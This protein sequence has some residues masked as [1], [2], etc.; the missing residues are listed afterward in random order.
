MSKEE[1]LAKLREDMEMR[2]FSHYTKEA[3]E[4]EYDKNKEELVKDLEKYLENNRKGLLRYQY[5]L[6]LTD[7][8]APKNKNKKVIIYTYQKSI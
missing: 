3:V 4:L 2:G 6:G 5:D 7:T 1:V 8:R